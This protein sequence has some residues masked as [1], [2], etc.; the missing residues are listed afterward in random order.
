MISKVLNYDT[1][2]RRFSSFDISHLNGMTISGETFNHLYHEQYYGRKIN[3]EY[4]I[5]RS[6][7]KF[8]EDYIAPSNGIVYRVTIPNDSSVKI[9]NGY[10]IVGTVK[11]GTDY[12]FRDFE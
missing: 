7:K 5:F 3:D 12:T 10:G 1:V 4:I 9:K 6:P 2:L 8:R 11:H